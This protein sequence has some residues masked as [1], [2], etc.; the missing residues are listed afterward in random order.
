[1]KLTAE[2]DEI[3]HD[4]RSNDSD[5]ETCDWCNELHSEDHPWTRFP[6]GRQRCEGCD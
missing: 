2:Q 5:L 6:D 3:I 1:M 4:E